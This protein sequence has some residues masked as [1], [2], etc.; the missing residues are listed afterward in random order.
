MA[1][2]TLIETVFQWN[3]FNFGNFFS[4][5]NYSFLIMTLLM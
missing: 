4:L 5:K 2:P 3:N 1:V